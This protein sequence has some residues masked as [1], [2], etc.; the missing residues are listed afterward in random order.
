V[1]ENREADR[2]RQGQEP[3]SGGE[4][5]MPNPGLL[6]GATA[7]RRPGA[8]PDVEQT[9]D[10]LREIHD[11]LGAVLSVG[12]LIALEDAG[13]LIASA[14]AARATRAAEIAAAVKPWREMVQKLYDITPHE[15]EMDYNNLEDARRHGVVMDAARSLLSP[16]GDAA[17]R[18]E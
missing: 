18:K 8:G 1:S 16:P 10:A 14:N 12:Q 6:P 3:S 9:L 4:D 2:E 13:E 11:G 17:E 5:T 15:T 7:E